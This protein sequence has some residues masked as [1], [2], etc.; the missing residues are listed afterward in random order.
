MNLLA[1]KVQIRSL[2]V[3]DRP[4]GR[5]EVQ[6]RLISPAGELTVLGDGVTAIRHFC[7]VE[8]REGKL[9]GNHYHKLR[10]ES[11]YVIAGEV[12][13]QVQ[14][15]ATGERKVALIRSGDLAQIAPEISHTFVPR[16]SGHA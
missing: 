11:F 7:Y 15:H 3:T 4:T 1:G 14:D 5:A 12:E 9:R 6:A 2:L 16:S 10:R 8:L 13:L